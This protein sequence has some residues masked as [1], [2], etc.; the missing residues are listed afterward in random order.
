MGGGGRGGSGPRSG[1]GRIGGIN[2]GGRSGR[3]LG[4]AGQAPAG[5]GR[6]VTG[7]GNNRGG[8]FGTGFGLGMGTGMMMGGRRNVWGG[9]SGNR[10]FGNNRFGNSRGFGHRGGSGSLFF[11]AI[12]I[13]LAV[14][15]LGQ[16][17]AI[18]GFRNMSV[19]PSTVQREALPRNSAVD[20]V[21]MFTDN[22]GWIRNENRLIPGLRDFHDRTGVRPHLYLTDNIWGGT[23]LP[24][25]E[26]LSRFANWTYD[27]LFADEAHV[28]LV[29]FENANG[30]RAMYVAPGRQAQTVMDSEARNILMDFVERYYYSDADEET[31]FSNAF[32]GTGRRIMTVTRSQWIPVFMVLGVLVVLLVL[33][34]WWRKHQAQKNLEAEQ[35]ERILGQT[36]DTFGSEGS[37]ETSGLAELYEEHGK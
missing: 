21:P 7:G 34:A 22:I 17:R 19:S 20:N 13:I 31:L 4:G 10:G 32:A 9:G 37:D 1:S 15:I 3:G 2:P 29:F 28:L 6:N 23:A 12:F 25:M 36:L 8:G 27:N 26:Q 30:Q 35:T 5:G 16:T 24:G 18:G 11:I 33:F 14:V